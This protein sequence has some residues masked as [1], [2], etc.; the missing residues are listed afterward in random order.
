MHNSESLTDR[1]KGTKE[2]TKTS[3]INDTWSFVLKEKE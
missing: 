1:L 3:M 2:S